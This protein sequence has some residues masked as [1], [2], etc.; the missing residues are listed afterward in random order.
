MIQYANLLPVAGVVDAFWLSN[1]AGKVIVVVL[2]LGSILS[3]S[4][5][6]TKWRELGHA[7]SMSRR[8]LA[9]YQKEPYPAGLFVRRQRFEASPLY[10]LY[11]K[12]CRALGSVVAGTATAEPE[13]LFIGRGEATRRLTWNQ[14][15]SVKDL[16]DSVMADQAQLMERGMHLL[17]VSVSAAP[18]LGLLGTV[19]G[20][21]ESFGQMVGAGQA[22]LSAVAPG[23][24]GALLTTV[25]GLIVAIPSAMGYNLINERIRRL[26]VEMENFR[27]QFVVDVERHYVE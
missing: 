10:A 12:T 5:M 7:M 22:M 27:H 13:D 2:I 21:L 18:L 15:S 26:C 6:L 19:W 14:V 3:W 24:S 20:L 9:A 17:A 23:I 25:I 1:M 11:E 8:F 4:L 16:A